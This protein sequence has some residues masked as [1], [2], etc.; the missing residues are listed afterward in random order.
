MVRVRR[1]SCLCRL[2]FRLLCCPHCRLR[3]HLYRCF[4]GLEW[5]IPAV[6]IR[7]ARDLVN[8]APYMVRDG[9]CRKYLPGYLV[10]LGCED[11]M[12]SVQKASWCLELQLDNV[13]RTMNLLLAKWVSP[14]LTIYMGCMDLVPFDRSCMFGIG[15]GV[16]S[17]EKSTLKSTGFVDNHSHFL[18]HMHR[19]TIGV[20]YKGRAKGHLYWYLNWYRS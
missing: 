10:I 4:P 18:L 17:I 16:S 14:R 3:Q 1:P 8:T 20:Q 9:D 7:A 19:D 12:V 2:R 5:V 11:F 13:N 15:G 6:R